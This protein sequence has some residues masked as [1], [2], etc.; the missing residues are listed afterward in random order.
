MFDHERLFPHSLFV[1][2]AQRGTTMVVIVV[3]AAGD[4]RVERWCNGG[5]GYATRLSVDLYCIIIFHIYSAYYSSTV[6]KG[7]TKRGGRSV[8]VGGGGPLRRTCS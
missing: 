7:R 8:G 1:E 6:G 5:N 4:N 2:S 3:A